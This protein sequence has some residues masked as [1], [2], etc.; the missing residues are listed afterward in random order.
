MYWLNSKTK[1]YVFKHI[2]AGCKN[3]GFDC[4]CGLDKND[5]ITSVKI[6]HNNITYNISNIG[7]MG[8]TL[9]VKEDSG[10][11]GLWNIRKLFEFIKNNNC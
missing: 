9:L 8:T 10:I 7:I 3:Y 1:N 4:E 6:T 11:S 5:H 2:V